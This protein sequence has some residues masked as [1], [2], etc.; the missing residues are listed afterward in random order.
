[1]LEGKNTNFCTLK[2]V[3]QRPAVTWVTSSASPPEFSFSSAVVFWPR[4]RVTWSRCST[5]KE[6]FRRRRHLET[7]V[8]PQTL[9]RSDA[10]RILTASPVPA[11]TKVPSVL[12]KVSASP[13]TRA[14]SPV[15]SGRYRCSSGWAGRSTWRRDGHF[16]SV[17][18]LR[19]R[20]Y[21]YPRFAASA[22]KH[23]RLSFLLRNLL[24]VRPSARRRI[25][26]NESN[27]GQKRSRLHLSILFLTET[28]IKSV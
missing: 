5:E 12:I 28:L 20:T 24:T 14:R 26:L 8:S 11:M 25:H 18:T 6:G 22:S 7:R 16:N 2:S 3:W 15:S 1:M 27:Q 9:W 17:R 19:S 13:G 23:G 10:Q 21:I 4:L